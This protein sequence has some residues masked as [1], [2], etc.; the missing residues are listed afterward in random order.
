MDEADAFELIERLNQ[1][2]EHLYTQF[3]SE[4]DLLR[5]EYVERE[6]TAAR[7]GLNYAKLYHGLDGGYSMEKL[8]KV[9]KRIKSDV[10]DNIHPFI[11]PEQDGRVEVQLKKIL[12][13]RIDGKATDEAA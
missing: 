1:K 5:D 13:L 7:H 4:V 11:D 6:Y 2:S 3:D 12:K 10:Q 8:K 9:L